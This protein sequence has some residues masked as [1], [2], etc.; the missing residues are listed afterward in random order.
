MLIFYELSQTAVDL[1]G[2]KL[3][4]ADAVIVM[5]NET[6]AGGTVFS[7]FIESNWRDLLVFL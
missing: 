3:P 4:L 6:Q 5:A 2:N 7:L 1:N